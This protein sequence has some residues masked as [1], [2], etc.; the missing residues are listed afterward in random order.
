MFGE[1]IAEFASSA[2]E[3]RLGCGFGDVES[4]GDFREGQAHGLAE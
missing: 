2:E 4:V 1:A 3:A